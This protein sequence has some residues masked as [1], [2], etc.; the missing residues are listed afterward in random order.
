MVLF[1]YILQSETKGR[2]YCG[3]SSDP[4]R[5]LRQPNGPQYRLSQTTKRF[6]GP[7]KLIRSKACGTRGDALK[8]E[9]SIKNRG[10]ERFFEKAQP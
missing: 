3:I 9:K 2:Y 4:E 5:R 7:W 6:E 10:I 8:Q 1:V